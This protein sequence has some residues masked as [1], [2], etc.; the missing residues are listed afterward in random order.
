MK[1]IFIIRKYVIANSVSDALKKEKQTPVADVWLD[2]QCKGYLVDAI[3]KQQ[4]G[5]KKTG[6]KA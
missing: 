2:E 5:N 3:F 6:F 4:N 1:N